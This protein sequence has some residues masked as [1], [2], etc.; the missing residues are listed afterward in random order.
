MISLLR[1]KNVDK[2]QQISSWKHI[3]GWCLDMAISTN[4]QYEISEKN[5]IIMNA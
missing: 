4:I 2:R 3:F 5:P 1:T